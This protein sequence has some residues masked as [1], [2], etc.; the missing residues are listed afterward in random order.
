MY[1]ETSI[2]V[3][4]NA[5]INFEQHLEYGIDVNDFG[6]LLMSSGMVLFE[7]VKWISFHR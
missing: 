7:N 6:D 3:L 1:T 4:E 5:G 2:K